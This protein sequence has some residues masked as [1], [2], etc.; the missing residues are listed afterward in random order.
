MRKRKG[1]GFLVLLCCVLAMPTVACIMGR[2]EWTADIDGF[3]PYLTAGSVLG[4]IHLLL[5]PLLRM[6]TL[7]LG[8]LTLGLSGTLI[9]IGLIYLSA[10]LVPDMSLPSLLYAA[11]TAL[12]VNIVSAVVR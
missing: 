7:P 11:L 8:C 4:I 3:A 1:G 2:L 9:D 6:I 10:Y 5:R 12:M